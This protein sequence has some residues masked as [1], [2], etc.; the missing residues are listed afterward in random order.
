MFVRT[1]HTIDPPVCLKCHIER[2]SAGFF[3]WHLR[4][5]ATACVS[6]QEMLHEH[7][8]SHSTPHRAHFAHAIFSLVWLKIDSQTR[9][10]S[11]SL[12]ILV[13]HSC[14]SCLFRARHGLIFH[15]SQF[16]HNALPFPPFPAPPPPPLS[17]SPSPLYPSHGDEHPPCITTFSIFFPFQQAVCVWPSFTGREGAH[18]PQVGHML[19]ICLGC[20]GRGAR[21]VRGDGAAHDAVFRARHLLEVGSGLGALNS[22]HD[23]FIT[24]GARPRV[25]PRRVEPPCCPR[26]E[27]PVMKKARV[28]KLWSEQVS[29][30]HRERVRNVFSGIGNSEVGTPLDGP[31]QRSQSTP[32][33]CLGRL[34][35][36]GRHVFDVAPLRPQ[37]SALRQRGR[38]VFF[39]V[40]SLL[41]DE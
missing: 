16:F 14:A 2:S 36:S 3:L 28:V 41:C 37:W 40:F 32:S 4:L 9:S 21:C 11:C 24:D 31:C 1:V 23:V 26:A 27:D 8:L 29:T 30:R 7:V 12:R 22:D 18:P 25:H 35:Q 34:Q 5:F 17:P 19:A 39:D 33:P 38:M 13:C 20:G 15:L 6:A 10:E